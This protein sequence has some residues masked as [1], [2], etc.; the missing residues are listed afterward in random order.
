MLDKKKKRN[1]ESDAM[2]LFVGNKTK[3]KQ[4]TIQLEKREIKVPKAEMCIYPYESRL[5]FLKPPTELLE[6]NLYLICIVWREN[7]ELIYV[8]QN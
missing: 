7:A 2:W 5:I 6:N 3:T 4:N 8:K 1:G